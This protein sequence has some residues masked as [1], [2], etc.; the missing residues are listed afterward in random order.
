M[1]NLDKQRG[2]GLVEVLVALAILLFA[3]FSVSA[4]QSTGLIDA[5]RTAN[6][7]S[8]DYLSNNMVD[9]LR[10][11]AVAAK[12]GEF[13][14]DAQSASESASESDTESD[15]ESDNAAPSH[16]DAVAWEKN[17]ENSLPGGLGAID[18]STDSCDV[19]ISW[20]AD[21]D[22]SVLRQYYRTRTPL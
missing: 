17:V 6:H 2:I 19:V 16:A 10:S 1:I 7:F 12:A 11:N 15:T 14:F 18:C 8:L 4:I 3:V 22:G 21:L 13:N 9:M 20:M 5:R